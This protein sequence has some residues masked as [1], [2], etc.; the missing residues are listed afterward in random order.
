MASI[1][2]SL[3]SRHEETVE[4]VHLCEILT[5][6]K[7][8]WGQRDV[9]ECKVNTKVT[10]LQLLHVRR[11]VSSHSFLTKPSDRSWSPHRDPYRPHKDPIKT[12]MYL[13]P[14]LWIPTCTAPEGCTLMQ[15]TQPTLLS[16]QDV[17]NVNT[18]CKRVEDSLYVYRFLFLFYSHTGAGNQ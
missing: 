2:T 11:S 17:W 18:H 1:F 12:P 7:L 3:F 14:P 13:K 9:E 5:I 4:E 10:P 15:Q 8:H 16:L 6:I